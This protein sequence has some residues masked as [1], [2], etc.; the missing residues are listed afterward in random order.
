MNQSK[1]SIPDL[2]KY[3][4]ENRH[5]YAKY[6]EGSRLYGMNYYQFIK[7]VKEADAGILIRKS[8]L[9]DLDVLDAYIEKYKEEYGNADKEESND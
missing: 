2:D 4:G 9:V 3:L 5:R 7:L 1:R 8:I 6:Y